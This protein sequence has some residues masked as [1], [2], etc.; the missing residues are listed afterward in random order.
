MAALCVFCSGP[1]PVPVPSPAPLRASPRLASPRLA[2]FLGR[3]LLVRTYVHRREEIGERSEGHE[4]NGRDRRVYVSGEDEEEEGTRASEPRMRA[5][6]KRGR[7]YERSRVKHMTRLSPRS[8][9]YILST[10]ERKTEKRGM[11]VDGGLDW[12]GRDE[13]RRRMNIKERKRR[14]AE[15]ARKDK[16]REEGR[17]RE[18]ERH[19]RQGGSAVE[20]RWGA[21]CETRTS[22]FERPTGDMV[23]C[24]C[25]IRAIERGKER[26]SLSRLKM[27]AKGDART[28][29]R[30]V[31]LY[32]LPLMFNCKRE[33][34][35]LLE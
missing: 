27:Y 6:T 26:E 15:R 25:A 2:S 28:L 11:E 14:G 10:R 19:T 21:R 12:A 8:C 4:G 7:K 29:S 23:Y 5:A 24:V 31:L 34:F 35:H 20:S 1:V 30:R 22:R 33:S 18:K 13:M 3:R 16:D 9:A 32:K 17:G